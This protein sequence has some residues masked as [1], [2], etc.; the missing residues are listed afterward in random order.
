LAYLSPF[1]KY[2]LV[3]IEFPTPRHSTP[4]LKMFPLHYIDEHFY[5]RVLHTWLIIRAKSFPLWPKAYSH[6]KPAS[7]ANGRTDGNSYQ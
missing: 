2:G 6:K 5:T 7:V 1:P 4:N 3:F